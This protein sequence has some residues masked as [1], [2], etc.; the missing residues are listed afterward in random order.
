MSA[1][2]ITGHQPDPLTQQQTWDK[3]WRSMDKRHGK[4]YSTKP[5]SYLQFSNMMGAEYIRDVIFPEAE[6]LACLECGSGRGDFSNYFAA[7]RKYKITCL[8]ISL[9]SLHLARVNFLEEGNSGNFVQGS[10]TNLPF[11]SNTFDVVFCVVLLELFKD[12]QSVV[13]EMVRVLKPGGIYFACINPGRRNVQALTQRIFQIGAAPVVVFR[14]LRRADS[15][16]WKK[17]VQM[18]RQPYFTNTYSL[19]QY[20]EFL[21]LGGLADVS[22]TGFGPF[23]TLPIRPPWLDKTY[24]GL[25]RALTRL[26]RRLGKKHPWVTNPRWS[27]FWYVSGKKIG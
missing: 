16:G 11:A 14:S 9:P 15:T 24:L 18:F 10:V 25:I 20:A 13:N 2:Q 23:P 4:F 6:G 12:V 26:R 17:V 1:P 3:V 8:D 21:R 19:V 22:A 27:V 7:T 5:E